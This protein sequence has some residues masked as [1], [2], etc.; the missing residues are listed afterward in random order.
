MRIAITG[1]HKVGKTSLFECL[2]ETLRGY[3]FIEEPYY[4]LAEAGY[5]FSDNPSYEE[6]LVMLEHSLK[7]L[8][9]SGDDVVF[10]RCPLDYLAYLRV[11]GSSVRSA[12]HSAY[13]RVRDALTEIDLLVFVPIEEPD[14]ITCA[15]SVLPE[16]RIH[17]NHDLEE[18][19]RDFMLDTD[20][21]IVIVSGSVT[22]RCEQVLN[23]VEV[24]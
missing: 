13:S 10:D 11:T 9:T 22:E 19:I 16:L 2:S 18:L 20:F 4:Q 8:S 12:I 6:Y 3:D 15:G 14:L 1:T 7:Q 24:R 17:V 23:K 5:E 21:N